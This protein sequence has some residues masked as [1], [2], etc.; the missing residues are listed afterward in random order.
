MTLQYEND[1]M[2]KKKTN[3]SK[4]SLILELMS[5]QHIFALSSKTSTMLRL[6]LILSILAFLLPSCNQPTRVSLPQGP[7]ESPL[8]LMVVSEQS[9][10]Y[11]GEHPDAN[12][13]VQVALQTNRPFELALMHVKDEK[14]LLIEE[15]ILGPFQPPTLPQSNTT[16]LLSIRQQEKYQVEMDSLQA[17]LVNLIAQELQRQQENISSLHTD[18]D[19]TLKAMTGLLS[20]PRWQAH[21]ILILG[22]TDFI[23]DPKKNVQARPAQTVELPPTCRL[24][25]FDPYQSVKLEEVFPNV[26]TTFLRS[27][28]YTNLFDN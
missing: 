12:K 14:S 20:E 6:I 25:C 4:Q 24:Y 2:W 18:M 7:I 21:E 17:Y 22:F 15:S 28:H 26:P 5:K 27:L 8:L 19:G 11:H 9:D 16:R 1:K 13:I 10:S 23:H 3:L